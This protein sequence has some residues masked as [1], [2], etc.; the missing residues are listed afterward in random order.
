VDDYLRLEEISKS[1]GEV[2]AND[3]VSLSIEKGS[4]HAIVGENGAGKSTLMNIL[5]GLIQPDRGEIWLN[6]LSIEFKDSSRASKAGI[7]MVHQEFMLFPELTVL[8]NIMMGYEDTFAGGIIKYRKNRELVEEICEAYNFKLP[9]EELVSG[10][11]VSIL[12][13]IEIVKVLYRGADILIF[14]EPTSVLT[15]QGIEGLFN[16]MRYM[17]SRGKT[18]IFITHKLDE[19]LTIAD[20]ITVLK[21]GQVV[22]HLRPSDTS[23]NEL[24]TL[25]VGREVMLKAKKIE[26]NVGNEI[27]NVNNLIVAD[28]NGRVK[29]NSVSFSICA[30]EILGLA[31]IAGSGQNELVEAIF[32]LRKPLKGTIHFKKE[33]ITDLTCK[34]R[35]I[36]GIGYVPQNRLVDGINKEA[37]IWENCI[38]GYHLAHGFDNK[39][40]INKRQAY[41]FARQIV[42]NYSVKT[43]SINVKISSLSGGNIQKT[44]VGREFSQQNSLLIMEDPTRGIDIGA[45]EFI[46][47][48]IEDLAAQGAAVLLVSQELN[49]ILEMSDRIMVISSGKISDGGLRGEKTAQQIGLLM[50]ESDGVFTA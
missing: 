14:D 49:E 42:S 2:I 32:G 29:V 22:G 6:G 4:V 37:S 19:V 16:A 3:R 31:G 9:L 50:A 7:G 39:Y 28:D 5:S 27:L 8:E 10:L 44:I 30:G 17:V 40:I 34:E 15:P 13:Q 25:M 11:P 35:R 45:I 21:D 33:D 38:M 36:K 43:S 23:K 41:S 24:A 46:W 48:K 12:Q 47:R 1:F 20:K 18:I 26:K